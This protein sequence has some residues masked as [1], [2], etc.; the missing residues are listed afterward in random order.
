MANTQTTLD[1]NRKKYAQQP[2]ARQQLRAQ[3][4]KLEQQLEQQQADSRA[5]AKRIRKLE[6]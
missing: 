5:L 4:I 1:N 3:I 6:N 2:S